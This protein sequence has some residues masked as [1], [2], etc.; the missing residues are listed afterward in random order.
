MQH[1]KSYFPGHPNPQ[2]YR[3]N[4]TLLNGEWNFLFDDADTGINDQYQ[5]TF[6]KNTLKIN[7]PY[8]Y[9]SERSG[10]TDK[11]EH[12]ILWYQKTF[13]FTK[14]KEVVLLHIEKSDYI[15]KVWLNGDFIGEHTGAYDAF[16]FDV[17]S[18]ILEGENSLVIRVFDSKDARQLRGKQTWK[19]TP[20]ECFYHGTS[21]IYGDVW[22]EEVSSVYLQNFTLRASGIDKKLEINAI[23]SEMAIGKKIEIEGVFAGKKLFNEQFK[24]LSKKQ[25]LL[26]N[27]P[28]PLMLWDVNNP[29][30]YD[31]KISLKDEDKTYDVVLSYFGINDVSIQDKYLTLNGQKTYL[32]FVL[33]QGYF[34]GG[35]LTATLEDFMIDINYLKDSGFNGV[36]KH[37]KI[38]SKLFFY[39]ADV[40]GLLN[41]LELPSPHQFDINEGD[42]IKKQWTRIMKEHISHPSIMTYVCYNESWGVHQVLTDEVQQKFTVELYDLTK[43]LDPYRPAIS[44]DGWEHTIS[45]LLTVHNYQ[46]SYEDLVKTYSDMAENLKTVGDSMAN[47]SRRA[48]AQNYKYRGEPILMTEF[49]GIAIDHNTS[50]GW[51]YGKAANGVDG[52]MKKLEDQIKAI[53][54]F[55]FFV[56][57]CITQLSDVYQEKNGLLTHDRKVKID[58]KTLK[59]LIDK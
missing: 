26:I 2:A 51:G 41:W 45:D 17:T 48:Y 58:A 47:E 10:I 42:N 24:V 57:Y 12:N 7:V 31:L 46:E 44:N 6:P 27:I 43:K 1:T 14:T 5:K 11:T 36:R 33:D 16:T 9:E 59:T 34:W 19:A 54:H 25:L 37:E 28:D 35:D 50:E 18:Q 21:G 39:L 22:L 4:W 23:F 52:F 32:K 3:P 53:Y 15:T 38:E 30:L 55:P 49:A 20:F 56:G 40:Y 29:R 8:A 13:T